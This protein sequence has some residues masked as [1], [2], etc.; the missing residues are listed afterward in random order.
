MF[1][2]Y[3]N[4]AICYAYF[5]DVNDPCKLERSRWFTRGWTLQE[6]VALKEVLFYS[7]DWTLLGTKL[8]ILDKLCQI[9][10]IDTEVLATGAFD[11]V[12]IADVAI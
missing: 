4:A 12:S 11:Y 5:S 9:T 1:R 2:W 10:N 3:R 6:S 8:Q 7:S